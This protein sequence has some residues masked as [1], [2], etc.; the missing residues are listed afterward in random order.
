[1]KKP[2][3][4]IKIRVRNK[5]LS[6][7]LPRVYCG[8]LKTLALGKVDNLEN[9][10]FAEH[11]ARQ[12][13]MDLMS[14]HFDVSLG[15]YKPTKV[16][17]VDLPN[18]TFP[19][20]YQAYIESRQTLVSATTWKSTYANTLNH[21]NE[22]PYKYTYEALKLKDWALNHR[23]VDT[24]KRILMQINAACNWAVERNLIESNPFL[25]KTKIK[26]KKSKPKIHPF[27][28]A[29]KAAILD[30]FAKSERFGYLLPLVKFFFLTGCRTSEAIGLQWK[31]IKSDCSVISFE[32]VV[33][34]GKGG[35]QRKQGTKQSL[36]RDFP[37]NQQLRDLLVSIRPSKPVGT[38]SV[39]LRFDGTLVSHQDL[40]TA[41]YGK[42]KELGIV[43]QLAADGAI[44]GYRPQYN[45]RHTFISQCLEAGIPPLQI[46]KWVGNSPEIIFRNYAGIIN[47]MVV[48]E[49]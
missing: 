32:E 46:S 10:I 13:E 2:K 21:L 26:N 45:T 43:R 9:R 22:C 11:K 20:I 27:S 44:D 23:T 35:A 37:C 12:M 18:M 47:K 39:F 38:A 16:V 40:R 17:P 15:K 36:Q 33:V 1:M 6:L 5:M 19:K 28:T 8:K 42:G 31:H 29:E 49:F 3:N 41:W 48:P 4:T 14:G 24:T 7:V 30:T 25:G 34:L